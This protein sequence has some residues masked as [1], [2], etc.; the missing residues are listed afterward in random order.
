[1]KRAPL[2]RRA[3]NQPY[4]VKMPEKKMLQID[5]LKK[6]SDLASAHADEETKLQVLFSKI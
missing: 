5:E 1:M 3:H 2:G 6:V 4:T